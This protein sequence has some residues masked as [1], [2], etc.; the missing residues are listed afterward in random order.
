MCEFGQTLGVSNV[1]FA[2]SLAGLWSD[3]AEKAIEPG[4]RAQVM[5]KKNVEAEE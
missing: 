3:I 2:S 4:S 1:D 5:W